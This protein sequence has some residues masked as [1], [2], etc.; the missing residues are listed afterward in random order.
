[1]DAC[2]LDSLTEE[3]GGQSDAASAPG[4]RSSQSAQQ[5]IHPPRRAIA[6]LIAIAVV[7]IAASLAVAPHGGGALAACFALVVIAIAV[8]DARHYMIPDELNVAGFVLG[9]AYAG[10]ADARLADEPVLD[11]LTFAIA[12]G[13]V[14]ALGFLAVRAGYRWLRGREGIGLGD[15]KLAAVCGVWLDVSMIPIA[16]D[17]AA[18]TAL[19]IYLTRQF[20]LGRSIRATGVL[21]FG[22]F[23]AP[24]IWLAWVLDQWL[25]TPW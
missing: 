4:G 9:L 21:P 1:M 25:N 3:G 18:V 14:L 7:A 23:L 20:V 15:V 2:P 11:A 22:A 19:G 13:V 17:I 12:R 5:E 6:G 24:A 16:I 8:I 10:L